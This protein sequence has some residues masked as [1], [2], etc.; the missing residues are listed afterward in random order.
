MGLLDSWIFLNNS[1][2]D[3]NVIFTEENK[4]KQR[5]GKRIY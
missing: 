1:A 4:L 5:N 3:V 2:N